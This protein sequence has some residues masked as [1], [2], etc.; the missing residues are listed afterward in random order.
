MPD[1]LRIASIITDEF[2]E[3]ISNP[4][5]QPERLIMIVS[6][7]RDVLHLAAGNVFEPSLPLA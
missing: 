6:V 1:Y 7:L 3:E 4:E 2:E 5:V